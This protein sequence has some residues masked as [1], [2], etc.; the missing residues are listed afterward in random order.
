[1]YCIL[2]LLRGYRD[3]SHTQYTAQYDK[4]MEMYQKA[5]S[6]LPKENLTPEQQKL[7]RQCDLEFRAARERRDKPPDVMYLPT[8]K[9]YPWIRAKKMVE[10]LQKQRPMT[11]EIIRSSVCFSIARKS[12]RCLI[13]PCRH[14]SWRGHTQSLNKVWTWSESYANKETRS[15]G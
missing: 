5:Q 12:F 4:S 1:M 10:K 9:E 15:W 6:T 2:F 7:A 14:G 3:E 8:D 13:N 11:M